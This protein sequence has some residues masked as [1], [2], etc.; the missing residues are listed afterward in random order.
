VYGLIFCSLPLSA[1]RF[2]VGFIVLHGEKNHALVLQIFMLVVF[3]R[4]IF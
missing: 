1:W 4:V 2:C 3:I